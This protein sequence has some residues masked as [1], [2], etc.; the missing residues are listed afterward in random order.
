MLE[1]IER[2]HDER[3]AQLERMIRLVDELY[4][5]CRWF[6]HDGL[7]HFSVPATLFSP[8]RAVV[9]VGSLCFMFNTTEYIRVVTTRVDWLVKAATVEPTAMNAH[10]QGL[11]QRVR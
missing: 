6:L 3:V 5:T 9:Y 1:L 10:P 7:Q 4:P 8:M 2:G 11:R